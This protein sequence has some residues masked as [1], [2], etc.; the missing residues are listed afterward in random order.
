LSQGISW[1]GHE[2]NCCYLNIGSGRFANVSAVT[3]LDFMD[4]ARAHGITDW[5]FD[6]DIDL[7]SANRSAPQVRFLR[8]DTPTSNHFL[9]IRL[10]GTDCNHDAIGARV[11][12]RLRNEESGMRNQRGQTIP[13]SNTL[14]KSAR[15]GEGFM[16]QSSKWLHFG[17]GSAT[18]IQSLVVR[19][20]GGE[21]EKFS[22][23]EADGFYQLVQRSG[24]ARRWQPPQRTL[25]LH[26]SPTNLPATNGQARVR[27]TSPLPLPPLTCQTLDNKSLVFSDRRS[28]PLL[29]NFWATWCKPCIAELAEFAE[30][31]QQLRDAG[32][33]I[34][35]LS[36]D[37][38]GDDTTANVP[39]IQKFV[40]SLNFRFTTGIA[41]ADLVDQLQLILDQS[42]FFDRPFPIPTSFLIDAKGRLATIYKGP[43][44]TERL[45]DDVRALA[46]DEDELPVTALPLSGRWYRQ[47]NP[48]R[49][50]PYVD[51]LIKQGHVTSGLKYL[52]ANR[53]LLAKEHDYPLLLEI[54]AGQWA[55]RE[56]P[57]AARAAEA[58]YREALRAAPTTT[59]HLNL[60]LLLEKL[61]RH[62]EAAAHY[63]AAMKLDPQ[64]ALAHLNLGIALQNLGETEKAFAEFHEAARLD[65]NSATPQLNLGL[66]LDKLGR[67]EEALTEFRAA[68]KIDPQSAVAHLNLGVALQ[69]IGQSERAVAEFHEA[70]R[71]DPDSATAQLNLGTY[72]ARQGQWEEAE[73][74]FRAAIRNDSSLA[75]A[76]I[77]LATVLEKVGRLQEAELFYREAV[78]REGDGAVA[79]LRLGS[80]FYRR[81]WIPE[82]LE[83]YRDAVRTDAKS[84]LA[85]LGVATMLDKMGDT[86]AAIVSYSDALQIDPELGVALNNLAWILATDPDPKIRNGDEAVRLAEA[87]VRLAGDKVLGTLAA[88]QAETGR[89]HEAVSTINKALA[90]ARANGNTTG[91]TELE[92]FLR[93]YQ[94]G[95]PFRSKPVKSR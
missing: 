56:G 66:L 46:I 38:L 1:S 77:D 72:A 30:H 54:E 32:L 79:L 3:G 62:E 12:L 85:H 14:I 9:A 51:A 48:R 31:E 49:L 94:R 16:S 88:A 41:S 5:D 52:E 36:V 17:L 75:Q 18:E 4:D 87:A 89:Y 42:F 45:L 53:S 34:L 37:Q 60:G 22:G 81:N 20:P 68:V 69:R 21:A 71:L 65:P 13:H 44:A 82:A 90:L 58:R 84:P 40:D 6:G 15:A 86:R 64:H 59:A 11:E 63:R 7:W 61:G 43:V 35:A 39:K 55:K 57:Q 67:H 25:S 8:N 93:I 70:A 23:L 91:V 78:Q 76:Y 83:A 29:I 92:R 50:A 27:L 24:V 74:H 95:E 26:R 2:R 47:P 33:E 10:R 80:L 19:W 73:T 28:G